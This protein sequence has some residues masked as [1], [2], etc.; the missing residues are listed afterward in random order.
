M[1]RFSTINLKGT[2]TSSCFV[3][4]LYAGS[5]TIPSIS[6][7]KD[8]PTSGIQVPTASV[9]V[10]IASQPASG[11]EADPLDWPQ[12]FIWEDGSQLHN[13]FPYE[14]QQSLSTSETHNTQEVV[15]VA[16][17]YIAQK[18]FRQRQV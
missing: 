9:Q 6:W 1:R 13:T 7:H 15:S 12:D 8:P 2:G 14:D 5:S 11:W 16:K 4:F 3:C 10:S 17:L 18:W